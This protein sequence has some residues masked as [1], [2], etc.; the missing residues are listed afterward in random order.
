VASVNAA[1]VDPR[2]LVAHLVYRFDTGGL[3]NGVVN[4]L[5][6]L[7]V[8]SYRHVVIAMTE[9]VP[10]FSQR[11]RSADVRFVS[12]NKAPGHGARLYPRLW[13]LLRELRPAVFHTRNLAALECQPAAALAGVPVRIHGEHGRDVE[14]L[15]GTS[16]RHQRIRR[17]YRPFVHQY[18]ALSRELQAYLAQKVH[19]PSAR[20]AQVYNGV[21]IE[22]FHPR[23]A[24]AGRLEG[25]PFGSPEHFVVGTVGRMQTVKDQTL[26]ARA[27]VLALQRQ[28]SLRSRLRLVMVGDGPLRAQSQALLAEAGV[29]ELAWLPGERA[30][31]PDVMRAF[32]AFALPSLAEGISNT[33]L[34]AMACQLPVIATRVG[35]NAELLEQGVT[36]LLVPSTQPD[37]MAEALVTL[38]A[39]PSRALAMGLAGRQ[40]CTRLFSLQSMV[41]AY[42]ALYSRLLAQAA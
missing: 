23:P 27:F 22:R 5:N 28:P 20:I 19:V 4:L 34:E 13:R 24:T 39:D 42:D 31:V 9:V 41:G 32:D 36:G 8:S 10:A 25:C 7:P 37:A 2:P 35:G 33:I 6:H 17:L 18:I 38:A 1:A 11:V 40:R 30:D 15:D 14:D 3:E 26:L 29:A 16:V 21:D 12:L